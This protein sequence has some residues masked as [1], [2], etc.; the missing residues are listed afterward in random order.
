MTADGDAYAQHFTLT[1]IN[2]PL[3]AQSAAG[4]PCYMAA[5]QELPGQDT[6]P[7]GVL[8]ACVAQWLPCAPHAA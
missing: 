4:V 3:L 6:L 1:P 8:R 2:A 5:V 7:A